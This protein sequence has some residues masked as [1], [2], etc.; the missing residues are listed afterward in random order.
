[1]ILFLDDD[2]KRAV[3]AYQRMIPEDQNNTIWCKTVEEAVTTLR[4]Y[5]SELTMVRLEHDLEG[6]PYANTKSEESGMEVIR[7]LERLSRKEPEKIE[8]MKEI[9]FVVHTWNDHAGPIMV[10]R[11]TKL[12]FKVDFIP[13]GN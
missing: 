8:E 1:M 3:L 4:D 10:D 12:G 11:L 7:Y 2:P 13:F 5:S 6:L 9:Q